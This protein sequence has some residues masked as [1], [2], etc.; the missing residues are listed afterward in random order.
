MLV[1]QKKKFLFEEVTLGVTLG[2][3][4]LFSDIFANQ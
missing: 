2:H 4:L 3:S 1:R